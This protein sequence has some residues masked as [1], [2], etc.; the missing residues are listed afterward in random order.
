MG[1]VILSVRPLCPSVGVTQVTVLQLRSLPDP[2]G[3]KD[4]PR[5]PS[6]QVW[7]PT[8]TVPATRHLSRG[9]LAELSSQFVR[10]RS[11]S[12]SVRST[13]P[14]D[15]IITRASS[16]GRGYALA[17]QSPSQL[18][19]VSPQAQPTHP[20]ALSRS[21]LLAFLGHCPILGVAA[22]LLLRSLRPPAPAPPN[23]HSKR[24][25][26]ATRLV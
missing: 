25:A 9:R 13:V 5:R 24:P 7:E 10:S 1:R 19:V 4:S 3:R 14:A 2:D 20:L 21:C 26:T 18:L 6:P 12:Y 17:C 23:T 22:S 16:S 15:E 8:P 11:G